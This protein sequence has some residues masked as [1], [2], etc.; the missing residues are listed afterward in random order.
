MTISE[1]P[2]KS[3]SARFLIVPVALAA[4]LTACAS[5]PVPLEQ[6]AV[7]E[8]A[9]ARASTASTSETASA[10]LRVATEHLAQAR[11]ALANGDR[12][13]ARQMAE[14]A[15]VDAQVAEL[16]ARATQSTIA[17]DESSEAARALREEINR[18]TVR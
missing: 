4:L 2:R 10:E 5:T 13:R 12:V 3:A 7:A 15:D 11:S 14:R 9:V 8:A 17:A 6:M 18:R 16:R 1:C